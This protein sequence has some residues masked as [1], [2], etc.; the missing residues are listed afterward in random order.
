MTSWKR[1]G[2]GS[3]I[4][5][6]GW[7]QRESSNELRHSSLDSLRSAM[8]TSQ[9]PRCARAEP[10]GATVWCDDWQGLRHGGGH[11]AKRAATTGVLAMGSALLA[12]ACTAGRPAAVET[13]RSAAVSAPAST[14]AS[15]ARYTG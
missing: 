11:T 15:G 14:P 6:T 8:G 9:R 7:L 3:S 5:Q 2:I 4:V 1:T 10:G 12:G 13:S